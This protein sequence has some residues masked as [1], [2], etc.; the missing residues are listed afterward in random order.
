[1][2]PTSPLSIEEDGSLADGELGEPAHSAL[3]VTKGV[4]VGAGAGGVVSATAAS[5]RGDAECA[6]SLE[7]HAADAALEELAVSDSDVNVDAQTSNS[8]DEA[9]S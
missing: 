1:M 6:E 2:P 5:A 7:E 3:D 9:Q 8:G 4:E